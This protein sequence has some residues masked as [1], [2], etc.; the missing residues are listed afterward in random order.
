M[1]KFYSTFWIL[2]AILTFCQLGHASGGKDSAPT[3]CEVT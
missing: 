2:L 1:G 3:I